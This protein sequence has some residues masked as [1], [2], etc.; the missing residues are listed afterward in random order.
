LTQLLGLSNVESVDVFR[1]K[2]NFRSLQ[3][4]KV[5]RNLFFIFISLSPSLSSGYSSNDSSFL[6]IALSYATRY[7]TTSGGISSP[8]PLLSLLTKFHSSSSSSFFFFSL[9]RH[10]HH[11]SVLLL[12]GF[13]LEEHF[14]I[15][16]RST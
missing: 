10:Y 8:T 11:L 7:I 9:L 1:L 15:A 2:S 3:H 5:N 16:N 12:A 13:T 14:S 4:K 6:N